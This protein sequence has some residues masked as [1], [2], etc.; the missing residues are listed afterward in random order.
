M[1]NYSE[2]ESFLNYFLITLFNFVSRKIMKRIRNSTVNFSYSVSTLHAYRLSSF[3][4]E[5]VHM[6]HFTAL[7]SFSLC[8]LFSLSFQLSSRSSSFHNIIPPPLIFSILT[9]PYSPPPPLLHLA[10]TLQ[11]SQ[12]LV[13]FSIP[14]DASFSLYKQLT[15]YGILAHTYPLSALYVSTYVSCIRFYYVYG[16]ISLDIIPHRYALCSMHIVV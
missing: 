3:C 6:T 14:I 15:L 7:L 13:P 5:I 2:I 9:I 8:L 1:I 11:F 12:E 16:I 4:T 10:R